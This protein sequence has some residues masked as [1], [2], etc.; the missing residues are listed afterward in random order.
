[1]TILVLGAT[2]MLGRVL[3]D[4]ARQRGLDVV[5]AAR[6]AADITLDL[7]DERAVR[8]TLARIR[9]ATVINAAALIDHGQCEAHPDAAYAINARAVALLAESLRGTAARLVQVS[10]DHYFSGD[11]ALLHDEQSPVRLV[12]EYAR[13]KFAGEAFALTLPGALVVRT[14][15]TGFRGQTNAP[16]FIEWVCR[17]LKSGAPLKLFDDY[18]TSTMATRQCAAALF[19]LLATPAHGRINLAARAAASKKAFVEAMARALDLKMPPVETVS[20]HEVLPGRADSCGLDVTA[21]ER[22]LGRPLPTLD[23]VTALLAA[24]YQAANAPAA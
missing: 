12:S 15:I 4:E 11:G 16:T 24:E 18:F 21:A 9:P 8:E 13:T 14:N 3:V 22:L 23:A 1:M 17:A 19:D 5:G 7:T 2:G 10:T 20:V 6:S